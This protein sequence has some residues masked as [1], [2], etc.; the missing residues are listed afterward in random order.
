M[1]ES[2][3]Q[4]T[5]DLMNWKRGNPKLL[6]R[7]SPRI[8]ECGAVVVSKVLMEC[9]ICRGLLPKIEVSMKHKE[10]R[11]KHAKE[12][13]DTKNEKRK[14]QGEAEIELETEMEKEPEAKIHG[15]EKE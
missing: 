4:D 12:K 11:A 2:P 6:N 14:E 10:I 3:Q 1:S 5:P 9:P 13:S 7:G 15:E 8:C